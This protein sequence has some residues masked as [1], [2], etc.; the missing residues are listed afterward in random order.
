[1]RIKM[2][3]LLCTDKIKSHFIKTSAEKATEKLFGFASL[4]CYRVT[5]KFERDDEEMIMNSFQKGK[6]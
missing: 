2:F 6:C 4:Q 3:I 5:K 1:M